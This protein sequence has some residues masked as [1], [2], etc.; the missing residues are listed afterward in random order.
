MP[1]TD[2]SLEVS[3]V[4]TVDVSQLLRNM[5]SA[6]RDAADELVDRSFEIEMSDAVEAAGDAQP[7]ADPTDLAD[8][9]D[10]TDPADPPGGV[11]HPND[12][13]DEHD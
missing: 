11:D 1:K 4:P 7:P 13:D 8:P 2:I 12:P 3:V 10:S 9:T 6:L 5:A